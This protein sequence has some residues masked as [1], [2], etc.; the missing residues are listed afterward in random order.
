MIIDDSG[1]TIRRY[2]EIFQ[3]LV[4]GYQAIY[5]IDIDV[6]PDT[7]DGQLLA[8]FAQAITDL[9]E[10]GLLTWQNQSP[11][12]A[13]STGLASLVKLNG[14]NKIIGTRSTVTCTCVGVNGTTLND[15]IASDENGIY[16]WKAEG[17]FLI[18]ASGE[19]DILFTCETDGAI[20][21]L[22]NT[23]TKIVTPVLGW[24]TITNDSAATVGVATESDAELRIRRAL[25]VALPSITL[26]EGI[27]ASVLNLENVQDAKLYQNYTG[28][29]DAKGVPAHGIWLIVLGGD[30]NEIAG[31]LAS[32]KTLG[33]DML[34]DI[35]VE[36]V[37]SKG[38]SVTYKFDRP[39]QTP[40]KIKVNIYTLTGWQTTTE[41]VIKQNIYDYF[42]NYTIARPAILSQVYIP[43]QAEN[44]DQFYV[45]SIEIAKVGDAFPDPPVNLMADY[46]EQFTLDIDDITIEILT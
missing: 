25:S 33:C 21:A 27:L 45:D 20:S 15:P 26:T 30:E 10:Q 31:V 17:S 9:A 39:V 11:S 2:D 3:D 23:I 43:A 12:T 42:E 29:T 35:E 1:C 34:G 22:A 6:S 8:L 38:T 16:Q 32:K 19:L 41:D 24:Q 28:S 36:V 4:D 14:I 18:P 13:K 44:S 40:I 46:D 37:D 5:G 7:Q